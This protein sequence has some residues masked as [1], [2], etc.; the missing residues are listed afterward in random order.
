M[1]ELEPE[2]CGLFDLVPDSS[3]SALGDGAVAVLG[4]GVGLGPGTVAGMDAQ[5]FC[6]VAD[7]APD[8]LNGGLAKLQKEAQVGD[9]WGPSHRKSSASFPLASTEIVL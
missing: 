4:G 5:Q 6:A 9:V 8:D 2:G 7:H 1:A 3:W